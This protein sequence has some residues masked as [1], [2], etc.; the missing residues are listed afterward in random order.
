MSKRCFSF[1]FASS[2]FWPIAKT[3]IRK[4]MHAARLGACANNTSANDTK[5]L[6]LA[7]VINTRV[8]HTSKKEC[9]ISELLAEYIYFLYRLD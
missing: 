6:Y 9:F 7:T 8:V 5:C 3:L 1:A 2:C 4:L